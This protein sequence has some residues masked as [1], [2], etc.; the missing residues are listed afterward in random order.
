MPRVS[1]YLNFR[2]ETEVAFLFY[3]SVF[4]TEFSGPVRRFSDFPGD[5]ADADKDLIAH[6]ELPILAGHVLMGTDVSGPTDTLSVG[7]NV[8]IMLEPDTREETNRL[9][10]ALSCHAKIEVPLS[11]AP[12][13]SYYGALTDQFGVRWLFNCS[14]KT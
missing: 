8:L 14:N 5:V 3:K 13:G 9:F 2:R 4:G 12:W 10:H 11:D 7:N 1:T 6:V